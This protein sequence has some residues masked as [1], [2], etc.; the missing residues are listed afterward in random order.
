MH[1]KQASRLT[2]SNP[3]ESKYAL[4]VSFLPIFMLIGQKWQKEDLV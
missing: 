2:E 3:Q 4:S 1:K